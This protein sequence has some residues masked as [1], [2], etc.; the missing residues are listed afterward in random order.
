[1]VTPTA[2]TLSSAMTLTAFMC[3]RHHGI[4]ERFAENRENAN[5]TRNQSDRRPE[6]HRMR[7]T[8]STT[9]A[10]PMPSVRVPVRVVAVAAAA[11]AGAADCAAAAAVAYFFGS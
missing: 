6:C 4:G 3:H 9:A 10:V 8:Q 2:A 5:D 11:P 7:R 1:M